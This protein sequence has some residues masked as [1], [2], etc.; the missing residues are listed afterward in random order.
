MDVKQLTPAEI[1]SLWNS[2]VTNST[3]HP[4]PQK[5]DEQDVNV[6]APAIYSDNLILLIKIA[7]CKNALNVYSLSLSTSTRPDIRQFYE[8]CLNKTSQLFNRLTDLLIKKGLHHPEFYIPTPTQIEKVSKQS[9]L[10]GWFTER[11]PLI[12]NEIMQLVSSIR[13]LEANKEILRSFA[14]VTSS[15][16][17][18][19]HF[20]R[21]SEKN[22]KQIDTLQSILIDNELP[23]LPTWDSEI[24]DSTIPPF[25]NRLMLYCVML[26][27]ASTIGQYGA[28]LS[29]VLRKD[30]G[31]TNTR[32]MAEELLYGE[33]SVNL[34]I[35][36]GFLDQLPMAK[37]LK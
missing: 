31:A 17:L 7:L 22:Q 27:T 15:I 1:T 29:S 3:N 5:F 9:F 16:E 2:Y 21:G 23:Q 19:K 28:F 8:V 33:D 30:I 11:R 6:N 26:I 13:S 12:S 18:K 20:Q 4:L 32:L 37:K 35:E 36:Q 25:S 14:Q 10:A 24:T 34:M